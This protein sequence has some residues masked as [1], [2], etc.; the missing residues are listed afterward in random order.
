M[1][2]HGHLPEVTEGDEATCRREQSNNGRRTTSSKKTSFL[3]IARPKA[4]S[5]GSL[6][7]PAHAGPFAGPLPQA[8]A[9]VFGG[10]DEGGEGLVRIGE[11][12]GRRGRSGPGLGFGARIWR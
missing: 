4:T 8:P 12:F 10:G 1:A 7:R 6:T 9:T 11:D 5:G 3:T 2:K